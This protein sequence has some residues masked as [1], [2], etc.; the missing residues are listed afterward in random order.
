MGSAGMGLCARH[1]QRINVPTASKA[2]R[3]HLGMGSDVT[4][5][6][7]F[8]CTPVRAIVAS[9]LF[10]PLRAII[11]PDAAEVRE[12]AIRFDLRSRRPRDS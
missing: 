11:G 9:S 8:S 12:A 1:E 6:A 10:D 5:G 3:H 7:S 4:R 2:Q